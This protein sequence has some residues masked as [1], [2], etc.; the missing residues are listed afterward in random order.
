M[1]TIAICDDNKAELEQAAQTL[2]RFANETGYEVRFVLLDN[3]EDCVRNS[4]NY[5]VVFMDIEFE[6][7]PL[8][9]DAA[10][11]INAEAPNCQIVYLTNYLHYSLDVY[12]TNHA[13]FV[14]K[15]Q[16]E[17]RL[18]EIAQKLIFVESVRKAAIAIKP[19][20]EEGIVTV[21]CNDIRYLERQNR[22]TR[23]ALYDGGE[24]IVRE[25][26]SELL[27]KLP[28]A[29]FGRCHNSF[30]VNY[31]SVRTLRASEVVL[32]NGVHLPV[33]RSRSKQFRS[34]YLVWAESRNV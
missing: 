6:D 25:K 30:A 20:G 16:L 27:D 26:V 17:Q 31:G 29:W 8:G 13:W 21:S 5:D 34:K 2:R 23:V 10:V 18:P 1:R 9:I 24:Y 22:I 14:L 3:A 11:R 4:A 12:R 15:N 33:S 19:V 32:D 7:G 28:G